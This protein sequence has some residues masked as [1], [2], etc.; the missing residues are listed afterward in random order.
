MQH[1]R[2]S[3]CQDGR[4][5]FARESAASHP[6]EETDLEWDPS[7]E[8][9]PIPTS[10][11]RYVTNQQREA[12]HAFI[13]R[14]TEPHDDQ[15]IAELLLVCGL[16]PDSAERR[17]VADIRGKIVAF[18][19]A[20]A[21]EGHWHVTRF[22]VH[23]DWR[24]QGIGAAVARRLCYELGTMGHPRVVVTAAP[25]LAAARLLKTLRDKPPLPVEVLLREDDETVDFE[26]L[27]DRVLPATPWF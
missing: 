1:R 22:A 12:R 7:N 11:M 15:A 20:G 9:F 18:V 5:L 2:L 8:D 14:D 23:P 19:E 21:A 26:I 27:L 16:S 6:S 25:S 17:L 10:M 4:R 3:L 13:L 24:R